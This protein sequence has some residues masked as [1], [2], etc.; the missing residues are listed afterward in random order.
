MDFTQPHRVSQHPLWGAHFGPLIAVIQ[1]DHVL[2][3]YLCWPEDSDLTPALSFTLQQSTETTG[4]KA[5]SDHISNTYFYIHINFISILRFLAEICLLGFWFWLYQ[6]TCQFRENCYF[7]SI[8]AL[9]MFILVERLT[10]LEKVFISHYQLHDTYKI[11]IIYPSN[12]LILI[13]LYFFL[14]NT[15]WFTDVINYFT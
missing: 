4:C 1:W 9:S 3:P 6:S 8:L 10:L 12:I 11:I 15:L 7:N 2:P 5:S 14:I 13:L